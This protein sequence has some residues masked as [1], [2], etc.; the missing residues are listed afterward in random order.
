MGAYIIICGVMIGSLILALIRI[1]QKK[2]VI[3]NA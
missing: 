1:V 2:E 3:D